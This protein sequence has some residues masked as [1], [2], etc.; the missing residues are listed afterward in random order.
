MK[1]IQELSKC[2]F[3]SIPIV[4]L[5]ICCLPFPIP[6][7]PGNLCLCK[8]FILSLLWGHHR[9][10]YFHKFRFLKMSTKEF[11]FILSMKKEHSVKANY[12]QSIIFSMR[13]AS[14][15]F[16][17][18]FQVIYP[19]YYYF[20]DDVLFICFIFSFINLILYWYFLLIHLLFTCFKFLKFHFFIAFSSF[21]IVNTIT[22]ALIPSPLCAFILFFN[23]KS[24]I[25]IISFEFHFI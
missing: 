19:F 13:C 10:V 5:F 14:F 6:T 2:S 3:V 9:K 24:I 22:D 20:F 23:N 11:E 7:L 25:S 18:F 15:I 12:T 1:I 16:Y 4:T 17:V 8:C 21:F